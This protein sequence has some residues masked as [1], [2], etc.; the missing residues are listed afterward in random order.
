MTSQNPN[1]FS[2]RSV[3]SEKFLELILLFWR[4]FKKSLSKT[5]FLHWKQET[6]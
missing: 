6:R 3:K 4:R 5:I 1:N 2:V